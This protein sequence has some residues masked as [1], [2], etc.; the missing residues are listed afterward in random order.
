MK[1]KF[2][3]SLSKLAIII[4][5]AFVLFVHFH[6]QIYKAEN[7][8]ISWDVISYYA[9]LPAIFI[10]DDITLSFVG[11]YDGPH[12]FIIWYDKTEEGKRFL[13]YTM[14]M[15]IMY[16]PFFGLGH[17]SAHILEYDTGGYSTPYK[18]F[19]QL[20]AIV[21][22]ILGLILL[23]K[24]LL[25]YFSELV[26]FIT[27]LAV[28][29]GTNVLFYATLENT[30]PHIHNFFL[31]TLFLWF[32]LKWHDHPSWKN[33]FFIGVVTGLITLVRPFDAIIVLFFIFFN[34]YNFKTLGNKIS[35]FLSKWPYILL[36][37]VTGILVLFPQFLYWKKATGHWFYYTYGVSGGSFYFDN[38]QIINGLF[39]FRKG[40]L[41]YT[42]VMIFALSGMFFIRKQMKT[43]F[44]SVVV[45]FVILLYF[46]F[47]WW[48][49]WYGGGLSIRSLVEFYPV[50][51]IPLALAIKNVLT[52][53]KYAVK[54][55]IGLVFLFFC[56][57]G[58][59]YNLQYD[60]GI[61]HY[62][63]MTKEAYKAIFLKLKYP[64]DYRELL[65]KPD[66]EKA[67]Q[68]IY[69]CRPLDKK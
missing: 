34:V 16:S 26:T 30:M 60:K 17:L 38:P 15:A 53:K 35:F 33:S 45:F 48:S 58:F 62:D 46:L 12:D 18:F 42:P 56:F 25:R 55:A 59:F 67:R 37:V 32:A 7:R 21:Y 44:F 13:R 47:S 3:F 31:I 54:M 49:W 64:P 43:Y 22:F 28:S 66:Y 61:L 1:L 68:G 29:L 36:I 41:I 24:I 50:F 4:V 69:I 65:C 9:Y 14:G 40:W 8:V 39:S 27:L 19:L 5:A 2:N 23:R 57:L 63:S 52:L 11:E 51:S 6:R 10:Y 20:G